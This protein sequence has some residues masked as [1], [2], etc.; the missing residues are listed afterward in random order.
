M[1]AILVN[2]LKLIDTPRDGALLRYAIG[3]EYFKAGDFAAALVHLR[4]A[5]AGDSTHSASWK[6]LGKTLAATGAL[7]EALTTW[8]A[9]I[10][11]AEKRGDRQAMKEMAVFA[12]RIEKR[13]A[14]GDR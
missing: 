3:N 2:L 12:R 1:N 5:V 9:G 11:V 10:A 4:A 6:L 13:L 8:R 14:T 7:E